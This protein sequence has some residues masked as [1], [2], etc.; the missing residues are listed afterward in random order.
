[1]LGVYFN[2]RNIDK[3]TCTADGYVVMPGKPSKKRG[4]SSKV[5]VNTEGRLGGWYDFSLVGLLD[6][7]RC[8]LL[9]DQFSAL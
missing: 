6:W 7:R 3:L 2:R 8:F 1:M 4:F 9:T 5:I